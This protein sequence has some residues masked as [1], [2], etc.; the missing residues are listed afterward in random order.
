MKRDPNSRALPTRRTVSAGGVVFATGQDGIQIALVVRNE[1]EIWALPKGTPNSGETLEDAAA[2]EVREETGLT[3][4]RLGDLGTIEYWFVSRDE[5][6]RYHKI[7]YHYL[8]RATGGSVEDHDHE[9]DR[10]EW[11]PID[12]AGEIMSYPNE[13]SVVRRAETML[14]GILAD[15]HG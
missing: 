2:R 11:M 5:G 9:Y 10:V 1:P 14:A 6:I 4:E 3:V 13:I 15:H 7:V 8:F 12:R